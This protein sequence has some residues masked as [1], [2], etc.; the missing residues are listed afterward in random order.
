MASNLKQLYFVLAN[1]DGSRVFTLQTAN[2]GC[3]PLYENGVADHIGFDD[4]DPYLQWFEQCC[5]I[6]VF[7]RYIVESSFTNETVMVLQRAG[8]T[9]DPQQK[10]DAVWLSHA[11]AARIYGHDTVIHQVLLGLPEHYNK[12]RIMPWV[13]PE[14]FQSYLDPMIGRLHARSHSHDIPEIRQIKNAYVSTVFR[15]R[16]NERDYYLKIP[17]S[18]FIRE[19]EIMKL[20]REWDVLALPVWI[21][22][23]EEGAPAILMEN[24]GGS[25]L[26]PDASVEQLAVV[27]EEYARFQICAMKHIEVDKPFPFYDYRTSTLT[28]HVDTIAE[29]ARELLQDSPYRL[30][31]EEQSDLVASLPYWKGLCE[32]IASYSFPDSIDHGDLRPGNIRLTAN[33]IVFFDWA[34]SAVTHPFF[35]IVSF[36]HVIRR[37][38]SDSDKAY[39]RDAYLEQWS[40]FGPRAALL[41]LYEI[42]E[43]VRDLYF[44][45]GD[46]RWL[47]DI[48]EALEW[49]TPQPVSPDAWT[50]ER[51]QYYFARVLRRLIKPRYST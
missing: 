16:M 13:R 34:W 50:M 46:I 8:T 32:R 12:S 29:A 17:T 11:E 10:A 24:M 7:R 23:D 51:R 1:E 48:W 28:G 49:N 14:G 42:I 45:I 26:P 18:V 44:V 20:I 31:E 37:S 4:P 47:K 41:E 3:I 38:L 6:P 39:L 22:A 21:A 30:S 35:S 5:S 19:I 25:D 9:T 2:G 40:G 43:E 27:I 15:C 33:G 36:L